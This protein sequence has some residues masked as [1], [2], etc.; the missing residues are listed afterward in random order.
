MT[1]RAQTYNLPDY[2]TTTTDIDQYINAWRA[3][4]EPVERELGMVLHGFDP[5][6]QFR[7]GDPQ[8]TNN[9]VVSLPVWFV[10]DLSQA[11]NK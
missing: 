10:K 2:T 7:K 3:L 8:R 4:A 1:K 11:L 6:F 5:E 9:V